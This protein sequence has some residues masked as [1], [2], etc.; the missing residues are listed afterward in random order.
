MKTLGNLYIGFS[1][2]FCTYKQMTTA[3]KKKPFYQPQ[4]F[5]TEGLAFR[6]QVTCS[7]KEEK[8]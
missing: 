5:K 1:R 4:M 7:S 6:H 8:R 2:P 3:N